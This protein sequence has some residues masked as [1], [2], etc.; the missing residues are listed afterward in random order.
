VDD[1]E[2]AKDIVVHTG[3]VEF[4]GV[5]FHYGERKLIIRGVNLKANGGQIIAFV[6]E[7][8]GGKSTMLKLL[9]RFYDVTAGSITIDGQDLRSV[10]QASLHDALGVVPQDHVLFN[11]TIRENVRYAKLEASDNEI[12]EAC[13]AAAIHAI[14]S[15]FQ[16]ATALKSANA[17]SSLAADRCSA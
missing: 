17:V 10:T 1:K 6:G 15:A 3:A 11:Q 12:E 5:D 7:T 14:S 16:T 9:F 4:Q 2:G 13:R 8:G